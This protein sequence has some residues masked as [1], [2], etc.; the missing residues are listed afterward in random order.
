MAKHKRII[1]VRAGRLFYGVVY[2]QATAADTDRVRREKLKASSAARKKLNFRAA[3]QK[4]AL[5][6]AANFDERDFLV[7]FTYDDEHLPAAKETAVNCLRKY[8]R[9]LRGERAKRKLLLKYV[10]VTE[11]QH[12]AG[13]VHHHMVLNG[14]DGDTEL[15][16]SLWTGGAIVDIK[17]IN[18]REYAALAQYLTKEPRDAGSSNGKRSWTPSLNLVKPERTSELVEDYVTIS[19]PPGA[20]ILETDGLQ[21]SWGSYT[22]IMC[23]LPPLPRTQTS[24][25]RRRKNE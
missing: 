24:A 9:V 13:R 19:A 7:T 4:L 3:W 23:L 20:E 10:Y 22:Y 18:P 12:G 2:T 8:I 25:N 14:A 5:L 11:D 15:I 21:N 17:P 16:R 6:L 1:T